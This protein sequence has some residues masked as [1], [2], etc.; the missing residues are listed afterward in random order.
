MNGSFQACSEYSINALGA[1]NIPSQT[2]FGV[3][4]TYGKTWE[5]PV[6]L[7][8]PNWREDEKR[9]SRYKINIFE[10]LEKGL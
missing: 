5:M 7:R 9:P 4:R 8:T 1:Y 6:Y 3:H 10:N 2:I